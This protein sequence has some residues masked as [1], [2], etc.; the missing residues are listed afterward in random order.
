[1]A[2]GLPLCG[3]GHVLYGHTRSLF[4]GRGGHGHTRIGRGPSVY[5][6]RELC[7]FSLAKGRTRGGAQGRGCAGEKPS[8]Q[9][10]RMDAPTTESAWY[11]VACPDRCDRNTEGKGVG[12]A[13]ETRDQT[14]DAHGETRRED[15]GI[16]A[17]SES[18]RRP[19]C[20]TRFFVCLQ[21]R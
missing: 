14:R 8:S 1:M 5:I 12:S 21:E 2:G 7:R 4:P 19:R 9:R 17:H 6:P 15:P 3:E 10:T 11:Q 13:R 16:G 18:V 20:D